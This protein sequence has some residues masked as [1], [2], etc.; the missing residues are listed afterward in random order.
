MACS[1]RAGLAITE[2]LAHEFAQ[3]KIPVGVSVVGPGPVATPPM[4]G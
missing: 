2:V 1:K 3:F 4:L